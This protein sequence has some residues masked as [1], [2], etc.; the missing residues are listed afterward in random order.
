M[1][2]IAYLDHVATT[3]AGRSYKQA[4]LQALSPSRAHIVLDV[5]CGPGTDLP[6]LAALAGTVIGVDHDQT[7][8]TEAT[9]R[10]AALPNVRVLTADAHTLPLDANTIDRARVDRVLQHVTSPFAVLTELHRVLRPTGLAALAEPDWETLTT[11][12]G[13]PDTTRAFTRHLRTDVVRNATIGRQL[14]RLAEQAGLTVHSA[15]AT[16]PVF[17]D[18]TTADRLFALTR[19]TTR[20]INAGHLDPQA[21]ADW[22]EA[23]TTGPFLATVTLHVVVVSPRRSGR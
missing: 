6:A 7:M 15:T 12:P 17:R 10:T 4:L 5:G 2:D 1:A 8:T 3:P 22:L 16:T 20:A 14:T 21:G 18:F 19:N 23:L 11:D 13:D 9:R